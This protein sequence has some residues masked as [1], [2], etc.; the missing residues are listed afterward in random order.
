MCVVCLCVCVHVMFSFYMSCR[1][2]TM[3]VESDDAFYQHSVQGVLQCS[4]EPQRIV[5]IVS[6]VWQ[7]MLLV[8]LNLC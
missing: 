4:E 8:L 3:P 1:R 7:S 5:N 2:L 6:F